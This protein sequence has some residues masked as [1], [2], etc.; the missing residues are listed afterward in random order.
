MRENKIKP[1]SISIVHEKRIKH[2]LF[3][4][5]PLSLPAFRPWL[6]SSPLSS[7]ARQPLPSHIHRRNREP[8]NNC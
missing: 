6:G 2:I 8:A 5:Q 7:P 1:Q 4:K 3:G